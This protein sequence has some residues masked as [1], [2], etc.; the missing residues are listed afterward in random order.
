MNS[1]RKAGGSIDSRTK[2]RPAR[3]SGSRYRASSRSCDRIIW[4]DTPAQSFGQE[5]NELSHAFPA[6]PRRTHGSGRDAQITTFLRPWYGPSQRRLTMSELRAGPVASVFVDGVPGAVP[7]VEL[8]ADLIA[9]GSPV[10]RPGRHSDMPNKPGTYF[11]ST[12]EDLVQYDSQLEA[13]FLLFADQDP[14]VLLIRSQPFSVWAVVDGKV[15]KHTPDFALLCR[16]GTVRIVNV[17]PLRRIVQADVRHLHEWVE[18]TV[19]QAGFLHEEYAG[20]PRTVLRN[21]AFL[22][23]ARV[24]MWMQ[25]YP[26]RAVL[27]AWRPGDT[28]GRLERRLSPTLHRAIV[29]PCIRNLLWRSQFT[30]DLTQP[31][32]S[33]SALERST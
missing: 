3:I 23:G 10:R 8:T 16:D 4:K 28:M 17:K 14:N 18:R 27:D 33:L 20:A 25:K 30:T 1:R 29:R 21:L 24:E 12:N 15:R 5:P 2:K 22:S 19:A 11:A 9:R 6:P 32:G 31:L 13:E 26:V 7:L